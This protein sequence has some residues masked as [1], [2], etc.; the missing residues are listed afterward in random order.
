M[1]ESLKEMKRD[2]RRNR[3]WQWKVEIIINNNNNNREEEE[4]I[5]R[6]RK[7][8]KQKSK[9]KEIVKRKEREIFLRCWGATSSVACK[10]FQFL[11]GLLTFILSV[12]LLRD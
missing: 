10:R 2:G 6:R 11:L 1:K 5:N 3:K 4:E 9:K 7:S 12:V 8:T